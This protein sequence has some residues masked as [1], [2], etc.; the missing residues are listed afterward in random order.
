MPS[1]LSEVQNRG[2]NIWADTRIK[3]PSATTV[4]KRE[5][6]RVTDKNLKSIHHNPIKTGHVQ[7]KFHGIPAGRHETLAVMPRPFLR[8]YLCQK[9]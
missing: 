5:P 9:L 6:S 4:N 2:L 8:M 1:N 3:S 7:R